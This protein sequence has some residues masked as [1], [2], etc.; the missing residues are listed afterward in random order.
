M[1]SQLAL[2]ERLRRAARRADLTPT[3]LARY[4]EVNPSTTSRWLQGD[5]DL[6]LPLVERLMPLLGFQVVQR[7]KGGG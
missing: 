4:L 3:Q 2:N 6:S 5:R 7:K 1:S